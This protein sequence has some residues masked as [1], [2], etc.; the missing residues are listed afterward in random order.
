MRPNFKSR[1][2][3]DLFI[4]GPF[5]GTRAGGLGPQRGKLWLSAPISS[6]GGAEG[7]NVAAH[8]APAAFASGWGEPG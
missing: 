3:R 6:V 1:A 8:E 7:G 5:T 4:A 2:G